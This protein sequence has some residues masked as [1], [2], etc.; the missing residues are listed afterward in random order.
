MYYSTIKYNDIA[1]GTG[2]RTVLFVSGCT[3]HC[4]GCFQ[5][6]TWDFEYGQPFTDKTIRDILASLEPEY[7]EGLTLLGGEPMEPD[8]QRALLVLLRKVKSQ[9]P[10]KNV[11]CYT[12]PNGC[13]PRLFLRRVSPP[14]RSAFRSR[15]L[16]RA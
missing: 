5:P 10:N 13:N 4:N 15:V 11:W 7:I 14:D 2:V 6:Q 16:P 1:N 3:H 12:C 9:Y 8:N